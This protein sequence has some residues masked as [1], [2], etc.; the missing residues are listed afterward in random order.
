MVRAEQVDPD[1]LLELYEEIEADLF[2]FPAVDPAQLR[3]A[4]ETL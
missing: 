2:K 1:R 3:K 4:V